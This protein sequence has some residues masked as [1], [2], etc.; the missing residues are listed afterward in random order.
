MALFALRDYCSPQQG[1][2]TTDGVKALAV[3]ISVPII[4]IITDFISVMPLLAAPSDLNVS[5][6]VEAFNVKVSL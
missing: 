1:G 6:T 5:I 4:S 3:D 2:I